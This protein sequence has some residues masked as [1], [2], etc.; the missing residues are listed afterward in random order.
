MFSFSIILFSM[1]EA[2]ELTPCFLL[3]TCV[4]VAGLSAGLSAEGGR[5]AP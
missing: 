2:A 5:A 1:T 3:L 4:S